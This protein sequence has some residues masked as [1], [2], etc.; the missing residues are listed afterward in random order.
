MLRKAVLTGKAGLVRMQA[1]AWL[2]LVLPSLALLPPQVARAKG[3]MEPLMNQP[4]RFTLGES[5]CGVIQRPI[6]A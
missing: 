4:A 2:S 1:M 5:I 6:Q 3:G